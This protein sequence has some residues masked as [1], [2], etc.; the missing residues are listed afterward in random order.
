MAIA[1][2]E[3]DRSASQA[4]ATSAWNEIDTWMRWDFHP[5]CSS[6][7]YTHG[8][9]LMSGIVRLCLSSATE[10]HNTL[11]PQVSRENCKTTGLSIRVDS[12]CRQKFLST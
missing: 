7:R 8:K 1:A 6:R 3:Q 11:Y 4:P 10:G 12:L 5:P 2:K 9:D